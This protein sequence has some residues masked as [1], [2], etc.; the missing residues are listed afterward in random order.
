M[1]NTFSF[2]FGDRFIKVKGWELA[3]RVFTECN[4]YMPDPVTLAVESVAD[5][6]LVTAPRYAW[7]GGQ[8]HCDGKFTARIRYRDEGFDCQIEAD[9]PERIKGTALYLGGIRATQIMTPEYRFESLTGRD[10]DPLR[11]PDPIRL[12]VFLLRN[13]DQR[14]HA[15]ASLDRRVRAKTV[16]VVPS[17][18]RW[19][20]QLHHHEDA[21]QWSCHQETPAW[22]VLDTADPTPL[23]DMRMRIAEEA[24]GLRPWEDRADVPAWAKRIAMVLNLH[25]MHW[26]GYLFN[27]YAQQLEV[28]RYVCQ[29][30]DGRHVLVFLPAWDG[31]YNYNWP[32]YE[33][34]PRMGGAEGLKQLVHGAHALGAHVIPQLGAVS[35]NRRF[36]PPALHSAASQDAYGNTYV[37]QVDWD[38]DHTGDTY[39]VNA[40]IGHPGFRQ[41]LLDKTLS[42]KQRFGF[43]G[44]YLDINQHFDNDPRFSIVQGHQ[45]FARCCQEAHEDFLLYGEH[46]YDGLLSAYPLLQSVYARERGYLTQWQQ[47]FN[48]YARDTYHLTL[49]APGSGSTGVYEAGY[50]EP[51][52]PDPELEVIPAIAFVRDTLKS[53][54]PQIDQRIASARSYLQRKKL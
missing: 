50:Q 9:L 2:D 14:Y 4:V 41:F 7:A 6:L 29:Q 45:E 17:G 32:R 33:P 11:Y 21:R 30:I 49:P 8:Q 3:F 10:D 28:I 37:K 42:L 13:T 16:A 47:V 15:F 19:L 44:V 38:G 25:G 36:L 23:F 31:R 51:W 48:R 40:N 52:V 27:D 5:G 54:G 34:D 18:D 22:R 39:R 1:S 43:D 46:W 53:F 12:P 20:V 35:A 24:W 26:T